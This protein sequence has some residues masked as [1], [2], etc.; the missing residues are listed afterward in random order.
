MSDNKHY[1]IPSADFLDKKLQSY[2]HNGCYPF[3]M[4]GHKRADIAFPNAYSV[5]ITEIDG[6]DNLHHA[7]GILKEAQLRAARLYGVKE[8]FYLVN[9]STCG[10]LSAISAAVPRGGTLL[11]GRN[12][13]KSAYHAA[14]LRELTPVY[15][16]PDMTEFGIMGSIRPSE[17]KRMLSEHPEIN[18][19]FLTSPTYDGV[20]SDIRA[21]A[22]IVH[23]YQL[24]LIVD[25]AHGAHFIFSEDFPASALQ[26]GADV[27]IQ[28]LHKT[29]PC[30][31]QTALLHINSDRISRDA[32]K[33]YLGIYQTSSP[34]YLLMASMEQGLRTMAQEGQ[35]RMTAFTNLLKQFY[36][37]SKYL[38]HL[39]IF[40]DASSL[41][42]GCWDNCFDRDFSKILIAVGD[43]G[44]TGQELYDTLLKKYQLQLEMASGHYVTAL[45]SLMDTAEGF[46]RL[47]TALKEIDGA[48]G[49]STHAGLLTCQ[50]LYT[51]PP[52]KMTI[53][54]AKEQPFLTIPLECSDGYISQ[55]YIYLYPPGIPLITPG[56]LLTKELLGRIIWCKAQGLSVEGL[57]DITNSSIKVVKM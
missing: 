9:G 18:G 34:S 5:D 36:E 4:P 13:H 57:Q 48:S 40:P 56:E 38:K 1:H 8:T 47:Y 44:M 24:P 6:F 55:E 23:G 41:A 2:A 29:L 45:T 27:V 37:K 22:D 39:Q 33:Q 28:S 16:M 31:T 30:F 21:I 32:I 11:M 14:F 52:R 20:V 42:E 54:Q 25:E 46:D 26:C 43:T 19:V 10:I 15:L 50:E 17:V 53:T 12:C 49:Y 3:H 51:I 35:K 7:E